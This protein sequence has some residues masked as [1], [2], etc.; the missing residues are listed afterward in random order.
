MSTE[1]SYYED[2][3]GVKVTDKR[4][5]ISNITYAMA[6]ITSVST[7]IERPSV[8]GPLL[9]L[10]IGGFLILMGSLALLGGTIV[11]GAV[12]VVIGFFWYRSCKPIWHLRIASASGESTP[13][14]SN[15]HQWVSAISN[16][17]N[18]AMIHRA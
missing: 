11:L 5:V 13:L 9:F 15:N 18:E 12:A 17:I 10:G 3:N 4:V 7:Y 2:Q 8:V 6:N 16:A 1:T 14:K